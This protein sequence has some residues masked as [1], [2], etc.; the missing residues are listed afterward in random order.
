SNRY[1]PLHVYLNRALDAVY[2]NLTTGKALPPSQV[3]RTTP[4]GGTLNTPAP[5]LL[6]SNVPPIAATPAPGN[7][8][9]VNAN[10]V[11]VPD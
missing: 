2:D 5:T 10:T 4:R 1:V 9:T 8:I 3:V 11:Q 6:P 7:A